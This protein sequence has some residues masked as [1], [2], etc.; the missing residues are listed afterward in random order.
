VSNDPGA[1]RRAVVAL[2]TLA[3]GLATLSLAG[4]AV[5]LDVPDPFAPGRFTVAAE[6]P[7]A[8]GLYPQS[9]V[10]IDGLEAGTVTDVEAQTDRVLV[11]MEVDNVPLRG[12]ATAT[13]RLRSLIGERYVE[14]GEQWI[15]DGPQLDDGAVIPLERTV[16][17]AEISDVLDE[18]T[19]VAEGLDAT[20]V[21]DV[22]ERLATAF[23]GDRDVL[24]GLVAEM[25]GAASALEANLG[26]LDAT[27]TAT[28]QVLANLATRD[29]RIASILE[30]G[31]VVT[32]A[33][34][35]QD[36]ALE[37][38]V[39]GLDAMLAELADFTRGQRGDLSASV[40]ALG[41]IGKILA[42]HEADWQQV[43]EYLPLASYGFARAIHKDGDRWFLQPQVTGTL[44]A[45]FIPNLN[46]RGGVGSETG[47]NRFV[48]EVDFT[49]GALDDAI[50]DRVDTT[51]IFGTGPLLPESQIGPVSADSDGNGA[52]E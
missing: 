7:R 22:V 6:F 46:S 20:A 30:R 17:P 31:A 37:A 5:A 26:S 25:S 13:L 18:A 49:D 34:V 29:A 52:V 19:R 15:G 47:D 50:P 24:A 16:V 43:I 35:T 9:R 33:L 45:P 40:A 38:A 23:A 48:P 42:A 1:R 14:L 36:G 4:R 2:V 12:D 8:V 27:L 41:R 11:T 39:T 51:P 32:E 21:R 3:T 44:I 28:D 10:F